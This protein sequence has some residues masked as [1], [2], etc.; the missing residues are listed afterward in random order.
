MTR[1]LPLG[2]QWRWVPSWCGWALAGGAAASVV[3]TATSYSLTAGLA[4]AVFI[5]AV[6]AISRRAITLTLILAASLYLETVRAGGTTVS[7]LLAP[8]ALLTV[9]VQLIRGRASIRVDRPLVWAIA[10]GVWA[11]ASG[12]WTTSTD[13][14]L[15]LLSSLAIA[16]AYMLAFASLPESQRDIER[17]LMV[18]ALVSLFV[19]FLSLP[20]VS[21]TLGFGDV[22]QAGRS[23][24]A[25]GD[26]NLFGALQLVILPLII[27]LVGVARDY[28][29]KVVLYCSILVNLASVFTS[30]SRGAFLGL[31]VFLVLLVVAPFRLLFGSRRNKAIVLCVVALGAAVIS[32]RHSTSLNDRVQTIFER[33]SSGTQQG[34]GRLELWKAAETSISDRPWLGL[35]YGAFPAASNTLLLETPGVNLEGYTPRPNGEPVHSAYIESVAELGFPGLVLYLGLLI[36]TG[37]SLWRT[38]LRAHEVGAELLAMVASALL[39]GLAAWSVTSFFLSSETARGFWVVMGLSLALPRLLPL[40]VNQSVS[41]RRPAWTQAPLQHPSSGASSA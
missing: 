31:V 5:A 18:F 23:Q 17:L 13:G 14:S 4:T 16:F 24:G 6:V 8:L 12:L 7:R 19:G 10:Y 40:G 3:A 1:R 41:G 30:L 25:V 32:V 35:G 20:R 11:L 9:L 29:L 39:L 27:V 34:S 21:Q 28:R 33:G 22:L 2:F 15:Y 26:P 37:S 36:S 38:A